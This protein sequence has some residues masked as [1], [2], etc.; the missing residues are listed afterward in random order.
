MGEA[1]TITVKEL[2]LAA[3]ELAGE[4]RRAYLTGRCA[5]EGVRRRV[6]ALLRAESAMGVAMLAPAPAASETRDEL[7]RYE[8]L[9]V[10]GEGGFGTVYRARRRSG[11]RGEVAIKVLR[12]GI[13]SEQALARFG[14]EQALLESMEHPG[15]A[16]VLDAGLTRSGRPSIVMELV[17]GEPITELARRERLTVRERI[18]LMAEVCRAV[19]HAHTKGVIHRDLKPSNILAWRDADA[20]ERV[21]RAK[22][23]DFGVA[24]AL[25][26]ADEPGLTGAMEVLGTPA[27]MS[28]EQ[29]RGGA[30]L[31]DARS[32]VYAL[33]AVLYELLAGGPLIEPEALA[34][35]GPAGIERLITERRVAAP[36]QRSGEREVRGEADWITLRAIEQDPERRYATAEALAADLERMLR[37]EAVEAGPASAWY[38]V[39]RLYRRNR[40]AGMALVVAVIA[41]GVGTMIATRQA[42]LARDAERRAEREKR[43]AQTMARFLQRDLLGSLRPEAALSG[44]GGRDVPLREVLDQ[45][46][47]RLEEESRPGGGLAEEPGVRAELHR[48][49]ASTY[50][51]LGRI[52]S[53]E[54][55]ARAAVEAARVS[56]DAGGRTELLARIELSRALL[57]VG[58]ADEAIASGEAA[59]KL[60]GRL[61]ADDKDRLDAELFLGV[62][63]GNTDRDLVRAR[64]LFRSA[65]EGF[66]R[67]H[68][69]EHPST[70]FAGYLSAHMAL[71]MGDVDEGEALQRRI[72]EARRRVLGARHPDTLWSGLELIRAKVHRGQIEAA[73]PMFEEAIGEWSAV[74]GPDHA[75]TLALVEEY[76]NFVVQRRDLEKALGLE[77]RLYETWKRVGGED[78]PRTIR[79]ESVLG[80]V[81][82]RGGA[83]DRGQG[84]MEDARA[85]LERT[86]G[87]AH[88]DAAWIRE[89]VRLG[90]L[91]RERG[92]WDGVR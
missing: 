9:E 24:K 68:G 46:A 25:Q 57:D 34:G 71:K 65:Y 27:Y 7:E 75:D 64:A 32:D 83:F 74:L 1:S 58:K 77:R 47:A 41:L 10:I 50:K 30:G 45:A 86:L 84:L 33:G 44:A 56:E 42:A 51:A 26:G 82:S 52:G 85:R 55:H 89:R 72:F 78:H 63:L 49:F 38:R 11:V 5:D 2:F 40:A 60:A 79:A 21:F 14:A 37:G 6:E 69:P 54:A 81:E 35:L 3:R 92:S 36:S 8:L 43:I 15:I 70:L 31:V 61:P 80:E 67:A 87:D 20:G 28:P 23:I 90:G 29:A 4:E 62:A 39:S 22:V 13:E 19:Q 66:G 53:A 76:A 59:L 17:R 48:Q 18:R 88:Y 73:L 16:R 12:R 91:A